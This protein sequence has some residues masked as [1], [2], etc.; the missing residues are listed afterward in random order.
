MAR[1]FLSIVAWMLV[2]SLPAWA[3]IDVEPT[4][5]GFGYC[6]PPVVP[7]C[8]D[9]NSRHPSG[10]ALEACS[11]DV[12]RFTQTLGAYRMCLTRESERAIGTG[13]AAIARFRCLSQHGTSCR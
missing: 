12:L 1:A 6:P 10:T 2:V 13:N 5:L 4:G 9:A 3:D 11:R 7:A 8:I